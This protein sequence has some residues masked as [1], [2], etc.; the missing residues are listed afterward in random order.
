MNK[1]VYLRTF[2]CQM[3]ERDSE[4]IDEMLMERGYEITVAAVLKH[5]RMAV[6]EVKN[7]IC[8]CCESRRDM[9]QV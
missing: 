8:C 1:K 6:E 7:R 9:R 3:D 4:L 5:Y 2:G